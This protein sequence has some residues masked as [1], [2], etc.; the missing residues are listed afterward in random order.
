[1]SFLK[2]IVQHKKKE[3]EAAKKELPMDKILAK[4]VTA[5]PSRGFKSALKL[6][7]G[8]AL[9]AEIKRASPSKGV[10]AKTWNPSKLAETY[11]AAGASAISV[12]TDAKFFKGDLK[13]IE[14][15]KKACNLPVLRKDFIIDPYQMYES[16][17]ARADAVLIIAALF[18]ET[19]QLKKMIQLAQNLSMTPV[20]EVHS[21]AEFKQVLRCECEVVGIN[22]RNLATFKVDLETSYKLLKRAPAERVYISESGIEAREE[23]EKLYAAG[24]KAILVGESLIKAK[25]TGDLAAEL[26]SVG[27]TQ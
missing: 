15:V 18:P 22:N 5:P 19:R 4:L 25:K 27:K 10:I 13:T 21:L 1:V 24:A 20:V 8:L 3:V 9:I 17:L 2:S 26:S 6:K 11:A 16:R 23:A 14:E 7:D 12:V